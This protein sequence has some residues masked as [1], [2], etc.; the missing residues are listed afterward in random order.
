MIQ[1]GLFHELVLFKRSLFGVTLSC[2][3]DIAKGVVTLVSK[4]QTSK[5]SESNHI[6]NSITK[7]EVFSKAVEIANLVLVR[8]S[9]KSVE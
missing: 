2:Y 4:D 3:C 7:V 6:L 9:A 5:P 8:K 1:P